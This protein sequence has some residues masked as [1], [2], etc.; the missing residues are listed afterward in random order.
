M[1]WAFEK[2]L[3]L[4][5]VNSNSY[6]FSAVD[7]AAR[8]D[9]DFYPNLKNEVCKCL[10]RNINRYHANTVKCLV[11]HVEA[12]KGYMNTEHPEF[13]KFLQTF[14]LQPRLSASSSS[15]NRGILGKVVGTVAS[16][17]AAAIPGAAGQVASSIA[18]EV[19]Q[20]ELFHTE[21]K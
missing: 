15:N 5:C 11:S 20:R 13:K 14:T 8:E 4:L 12:Q 2:K 18:D 10:F 16:V 6:D 19:H 3:C 7:D 21:Q 17:A 1:S 9:L